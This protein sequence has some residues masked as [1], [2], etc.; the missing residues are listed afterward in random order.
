MNTGC[1]YREKCIGIP[2]Q[3]KIQEN[4]GCGPSLDQSKMVVPVYTRNTT[5]VLGIVQ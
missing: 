2:S 3:L 1:S 4:P 5:D